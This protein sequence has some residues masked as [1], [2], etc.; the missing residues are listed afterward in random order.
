[1]KNRFT[2]QLWGESRYGLLD[3][4]PHESAGPNALKR[5]TQLRHKRK[6]SRK[7]VAG[8]VERDVRESWW[9][10]LLNGE[11]SV[12]SDEYIALPRG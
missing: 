7:S 6:K 9:N 8:R 2:N 12:D 11:Q 3:T 1:M 10:C 5:V 4:Q